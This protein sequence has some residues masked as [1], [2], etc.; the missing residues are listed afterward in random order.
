M[1]ETLVLAIWAL[2]LIQE[3]VYKIHYNI[4]VFRSEQFW[5]ILLVKFVAQFCSIF[6]SKFLSLLFHALFPAMLIGWNLVHQFLPKSL[7]AMWWRWCRGIYRR[8][9]DSWWLLITTCVEGSAYEGEEEE[10]LSPLGL[11]EGQWAF[12]VSIRH[13]FLRRPFLQTDMIFEKTKLQSWMRHW[14]LWKCEVK[15]SRKDFL[16]TVW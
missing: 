13:H 15:V 4:I 7:G 9:D 14:I 6:C 5:H 16:I 1:L 2:A 3:F 10:H 11:S 12:H 8:Y